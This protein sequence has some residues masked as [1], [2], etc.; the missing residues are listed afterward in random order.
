[1]QRVWIVL[2]SS[3]PLCCIQV[4]VRRKNGYN[5]LK[6]NDSWIAMLNTAE[7]YK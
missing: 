6:P 5:S 1:M 3:A 7:S 2:K 4:L